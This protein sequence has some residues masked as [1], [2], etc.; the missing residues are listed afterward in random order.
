[1]KD[2]TQSSCV[3]IVSMDI[4]AGSWPALMTQ[5]QDQRHARPTCHFANGRGIVGG[6]WSGHLPLEMS[7]QVKRAQGPRRV[8]PRE[9]L[10][11]ER[12]VVVHGKNHAVAQRR[13]AVGPGAWLSAGLPQHLAA[14]THAVDLSSHVLEDHRLL[15]WEQ[16]QKVPHGHVR[17]KGPQDLSVAGV[18]G[19]HQVICCAHARRL[20]AIPGRKDHALMHHG[21]SVVLANSLGSIGEPHGFAGLHAHRAHGTAGVTGED[22]ALINGWGVH[23]IRRKHVHFP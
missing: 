1:M 20:T 10:A 12:M 4:A 14:Q 6:T 15:V 16:G 9:F 19:G 21:K 17:L 8:F 18:Q 22:R 2:P 11:V 23:E 5:G 7:V 13:A 3:G